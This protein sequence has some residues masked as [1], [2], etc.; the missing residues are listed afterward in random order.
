MANF[1]LRKEDYNTLIQSDNLGV[2]VSDDDIIRTSAEIAT[3]T[4]IKSYL[5]HR[6]NCDLIFA[7]LQPWAVG[8]NFK[9]GDRIYL[10]AEPFS[11]INGYLGGQMVLHA[12]HVYQSIAGSIPHVFDV[13]EWTLLGAE[14]HYQMKADLWDDETAYLIGSIVKYETTEVRKYYQALTNNTGVNP[15]TDNGANW[16]LVTSQAGELP[17]SSAYWSFGDSRNKLILMH[18]I[19]VVLYQLH[20]RINPRN[21]P[22]FR[23]I[24]RGEAIDY[25]KMVARGT[26]TPDLELI[27]PEQGN[28]IVFGSKPVQQNYY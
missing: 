28:N 12:G 8:T 20:S 11:S 23:I 26:I 27:T 17:T 9:W 19:D 16:V 2:I 14:G 3:E 5:S 21:I 4:E 13:S 1:F 6:F 7:P 18:F 15:Y 24:R 25:L 22:E 10:T